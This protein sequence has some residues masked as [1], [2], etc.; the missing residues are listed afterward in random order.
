MV[1]LENEPALMKNRRFYE[2]Q[3]RG[4]IHDRFAEY[5]DRIAVG[6]ALAMKM[7]SHGIMISGPAYVSG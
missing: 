2:E 7:R 4:L 5:E 1:A 6:I 3:V